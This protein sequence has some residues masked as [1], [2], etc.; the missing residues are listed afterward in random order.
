M[1]FQVFDNHLIVEPSIYTG[2]AI[3]IPSPDEIPNVDLEVVNYHR[4]VSRSFRSS[5]II[6][7]FHLD[8][9]NIPR[10]VHHR[11]PQNGCRL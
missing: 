8:F 2:K 9:W 3:Q 6:I 7:T 11:G 1:F 4:P 10:K 5:L